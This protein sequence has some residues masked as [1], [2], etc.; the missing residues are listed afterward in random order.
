MPRVIYS[1]L[2]RFTSPRRVVERYIAEQRIT[3]LGITLEIT[4]LCTY[5][6][7]CTS[8]GITHER[9]Q[10]YKKSS[11]LSHLDTNR[12]TNVNSYFSHYRIVVLPKQTRC[13]SIRCF[14]RIVQQVFKETSPWSRSWL[15]L[16]HSLSVSL[17]LCLSTKINSKLQF[18]EKMFFLRGN[19]FPYQRVL[20]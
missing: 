9:E 7:I 15:S 20:D 2:S 6:P 13:I 8:N 16:S 12:C 14:G 11:L 5:T 18:A 3:L 17:F 4:L 1:E 19:I 10:R